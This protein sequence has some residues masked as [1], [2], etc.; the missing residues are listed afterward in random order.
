MSFVL[1]AIEAIVF[2]GIVLTIVT[3]LYLEKRGR[4]K[5][6]FCSMAEEEAE[7]ETN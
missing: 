1:N 4:P 2:L 5:K 6:S 7:A 3:V